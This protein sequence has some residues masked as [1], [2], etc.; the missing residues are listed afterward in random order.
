[1][2]MVMEKQ[3][4]RAPLSVRLTDEEWELLENLQTVLGYSSRSQ[5]IK[6]LINSAHV[7]PASLKFA[8]VE[9]Q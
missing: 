6:R 5:V 2:D 4:E 9:S 1:M 3:A 8:P 7:R